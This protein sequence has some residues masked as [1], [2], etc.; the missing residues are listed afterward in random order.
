MWADVCNRR[1]RSVS[2]QLTAD[3]VPA[4]LLKKTAFRARVDS[5][6]RPSAYGLGLAI[7]S[8]LVESHALTLA[9][10]LLLVDSELHDP[11]LAVRVHIPHDV[12]E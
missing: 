2:D 4:H 9:R 3:T 6:V 12:F 1:N 7:E 10:G 5:V 11:E 8:T